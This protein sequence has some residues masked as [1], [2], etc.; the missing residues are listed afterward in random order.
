MTA[1]TR[2]TDFQKKPQ[3]AAICRDGA[4]LTFPNREKLSNI[5]PN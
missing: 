5:K 4:I 2:H 1:Q 3:V